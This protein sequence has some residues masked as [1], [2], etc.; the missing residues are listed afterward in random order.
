M[1][2]APFPN[3]PLDYTEGTVVRTTKHGWIAYRLG[4]ALTEIST[5]IDT[6]LSVHVETPKPGTAWALRPVPP[7]DL[8]RTWRRTSY[9][10][11]K[12]LRAEINFVNGDWNRR[13]S[14]YGLK[15]ENASHDTGNMGRL[16]VILEDAHVAAR[17]SMQKSQKAGITWRAAV[18]VANAT[19][20]HDDTFDAVAAAAT[21]AGRHPDLM[22]DTAEQYIMGVLFPRLFAVEVLFRGA[23]GKYTPRWNHAFAHPD[24]TVEQKKSLQ[25]IENKRSSGASAATNG[26]AK[27]GSKAFELRA[28]LLDVLTMTT[29]DPQ[30]AVGDDGTPTGGVIAITVEELSTQV[31]DFCNVVPATEAD[32]Y[33]ALAIPMERL[34]HMQKLT[35]TLGEQVDMGAAA[36]GPDGPT[37]TVAAALSDAHFKTILSEMMEAFIQL[38]NMMP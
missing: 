17:N 37:D 13:P 27:I 22:D 3:S 34:A 30:T 6:I 28:L 14:T 12:S 15:H 33:P 19:G 38:E 36:A 5:G 16:G 4:H 7:G 24:T 11:L 25:T 18:A 31:L 1:A 29:Y 32:T 20:I 35:Q 23:V 8:A 21:A 9:S 10:V 2:A 26:G